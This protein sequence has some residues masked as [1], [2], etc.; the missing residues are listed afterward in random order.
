MGFNN[1]QKNSVMHA[2]YK[3]IPYG[4]HVCMHGMT[5]GVRGHVW[6]I[7]IRKRHERLLIN[8]LTNYKPW[9]MQ[10][11]IRYGLFKSQI[12]N[13]CEEYR[14]ANYELI[15]AQPLTNQIL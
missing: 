14:G 5:M 10:K 7:N 6:K 1:Q 4:I 8:H 2:Q 3:A 12:I 15:G 11:V 13:I 9:L